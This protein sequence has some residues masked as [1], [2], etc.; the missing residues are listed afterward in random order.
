VG[1]EK[2]TDKQNNHQAEDAGKSI[3]GELEG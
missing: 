3:H 2:K 1:G